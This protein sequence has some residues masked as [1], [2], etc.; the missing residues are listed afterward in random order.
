VTLVVPARYFVAITRGIFLKDI[1]LA[2]LWPEVLALLAFAVGAVG[3][4]LLSF[5]KQLA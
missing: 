4:A 1:G 2:V 3:L 5:R